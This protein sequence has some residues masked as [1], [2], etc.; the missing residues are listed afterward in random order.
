MGGP[1]RETAAALGLVAVIVLGTWLASQRAV[2]LQLTQSAKDADKTY[3]ERRAAAEKLAQHNA[4]AAS[5][6]WIELLKSTPGRLQ[7]EVLQDLTGRPPKRG[8]AVPALVKTALDTSLPLVR[9]VIACNAL[10]FQQPRV[11][12][13][14]SVAPLLRAKQPSLR[15]GAAQ[16]LIY[17]GFPDRGF[18]ALFANLRSAEARMET[19]YLLFILTGHEEPTSERPGPI[20]MDKEAKA[21]ETWWAN[22]RHLWRLPIAK[23]PQRDR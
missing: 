16:A 10:K 7:T 15:L 22:N 1:K 13:P 8:V 4:V 14:D 3:R 21:W 6:V 9:R 17:Q 11:L 2:R 18:K 20:A 19:H 12:D 23:P 5:E